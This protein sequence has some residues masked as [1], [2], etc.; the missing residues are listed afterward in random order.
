MDHTKGCF[1]NMED[2]RD[3]ERELKENDRCRTRKGTKME[4]IVQL[5]LGL[6]N[7]KD[8]SVYPEI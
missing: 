1:E 2:G 6:A 8:I 4:N 3:K 5:V 7:R